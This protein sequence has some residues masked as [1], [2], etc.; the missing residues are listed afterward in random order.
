[1][2]VLGLLAIAVAIAVTVVV[3]RRFHPDSDSKSNSNKIKKPQQ[4]RFTEAE[5]RKHADPP[6][7]DSDDVTVSRSS[8]TYQARMRVM[9]TFT[10]VVGRKASKDEIEHYSSLGS[11]AAIRSA[12]ERDLVP[13]GH[14]EERFSELPTTTSDKDKEK[15]DK[16]T[17]KEKKDKEKKDK[18]DHE[19]THKHDRI[20][21]VVTDDTDSD[22]ESESGDH[23]PNRT[24]GHHEPVPYSRLN[25]TKDTAAEPDL[26][27]ARKGR[28]ST[29]DRA[30]ICMNRRDVLK[31]LQ[32]IADDVERFRQTV[33]ML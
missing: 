6:A 2:V 14:Y 1:M 4:E 23:S 7:V 25:V 32:T 20:P 21:K 22:T 15:K 18:D 13:A 28:G 8:E 3:H 24:G 26:G 16:E 10:E 33:M 12:I 9:Q 5:Q 27:W 11:D 29:R 31:R 30:Q 19:H 17:D